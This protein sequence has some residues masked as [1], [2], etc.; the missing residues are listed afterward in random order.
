MRADINRGCLR[1]LGRRDSLRH[2][3]LDKFRAFT[4]KVMAVPERK[5]WEAEYRYGRKSKKLSRSA[6]FGG[7]ARAAN[8]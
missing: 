4:K 6:V 1:F 5:D 2:T 3:P 7:S 8:A